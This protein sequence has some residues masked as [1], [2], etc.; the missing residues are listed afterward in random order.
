MTVVSEVYPE[1]GR[2]WPADGFGPIAVVAAQLPDPKDLPDGGVV[3][4]HQAPR[5]PTAWWARLAMAGRFWRRPP[6]AHRAVT[7]TALLALGYRD[8]GVAEDPQ[9]RHEVAWGVA[10]TSARS[11]STR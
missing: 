4:V 2:S 1:L 3:L 9:T 8:V 7:C 10:V 11:S 5:A 6:R